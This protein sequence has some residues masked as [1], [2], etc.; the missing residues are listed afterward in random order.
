M[1]TVVKIQRLFIFVNKSVSREACVRNRKSC[2]CAAAIVVYCG[3]L[4]YD[5]YDRIVYIRYVSGLSVSV[6]RN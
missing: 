5:G 2:R 4:P 1:E 3:N 6:K